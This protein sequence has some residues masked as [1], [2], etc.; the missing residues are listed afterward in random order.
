MQEK[1]IQQNEA[2][3]KMRGYLL[4]K[5]D[6]K[7]LKRPDLQQ[8]LAHNGQPTDGIPETVGMELSHLFRLNKFKIVIN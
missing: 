4:Q 7:V 6:R 8:L 5:F 2:L 1:M 3:H